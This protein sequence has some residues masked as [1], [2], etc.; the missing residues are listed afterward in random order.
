MDATLK[1]AWETL[2]SRYSADTAL[3]TQLWEELEQ[4]Y[5]S[6]GRYY[7]TLDHLAYMLQ[8]AEEHKPNARR[9]DLLRFAIFYHDIVYSSTRSDNEEKSAAIAEKHLARLGLGSADIAFVKEMILATK[10]HQQQSDD[11][12]NLLLDLDLAILGADDEKYE[13]YSQAVRQEYGLYPD[14]IYKP[15]RRKVLQHFLDQPNIYKTSIFKQKYEA[16]ARLNLQ[17]ELKRL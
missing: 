6:K 5:T 14:I 9:N 3:V 2:C 13:A 17:R 10:V 8:L 4:A 11:T 12:L 7:H 16:K 15:G 1:P